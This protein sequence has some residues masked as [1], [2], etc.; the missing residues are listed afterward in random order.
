MEFNSGFKGLIVT[1]KLNQESC[2]WLAIRV[3]RH[4]L[5]L[6]YIASPEQLLNCFS[7]RRKFKD[8]L[9][10]SQNPLSSVTLSHPEDTFYYYPKYCSPRVCQLPLHLTCYIRLYSAGLCFCLQWGVLQRMMLERTNATTNA[11][12]NYL[13][14]K[15]RL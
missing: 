7:S 15:V 8:P 13:L 6:C 9:L 12:E 14:W 10:S 11:E 3:F 2:W 4:H 5:A 1:V